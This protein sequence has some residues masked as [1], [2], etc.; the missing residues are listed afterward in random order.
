V[1][2]ADDLMGAITPRGSSQ[3][4]LRVRDVAADGADEGFV[5]DLIGQPIAHDY[6]GRGRRRSR[7]CLPPG[8]SIRR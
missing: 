8:R 4:W 1:R 2:A 7:S 5:T 6:R 3:R